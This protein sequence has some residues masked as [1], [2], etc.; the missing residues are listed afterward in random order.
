MH[1]YICKHGP[2]I[3]LLAGYSDD[4][5]GNYSIVSP[6]PRREPLIDYH[7]NDGDIGG[8]QTFMPQLRGRVVCLDLNANPNNRP[9]PGLSLIPIN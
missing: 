4:D 8:R 2:V 9:C 1:L 6:T 5:D 7:Q 3:A